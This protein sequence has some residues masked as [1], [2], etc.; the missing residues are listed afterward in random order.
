MDPWRYTCGCTRLQATHSCA[1]R[2]FL[3]RSLSGWLPFSAVHS[4]HSSS[5]LPP[6][7]P[8]QILFIDIDVRALCLHQSLS[9]SL[10]LCP[11]LHSFLMLAVWLPLPIP[12]SIKL[13][14]PLFFF[15]T[16]LGPAVA[17]DR[18]EPRC[19]HC[20]SCS[21]TFSCRATAD[22]F[23]PPRGIVLKRKENTVLLLLQM[24]EEL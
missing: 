1:A 20:G 10:L 16:P 7:P 2:L 9:F 13:S 11:P 21:P 24:S 17:A 15:F 22:R 8:S 5:Y 12:S 23:A 18:T 14:S 6:S 4:V 3:P 19:N